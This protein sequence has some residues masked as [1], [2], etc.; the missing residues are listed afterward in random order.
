MFVHMQVLGMSGQ[1]M[2]HDF[3]DDLSL[4]QSFQDQSGTSKVNE[5][6]HG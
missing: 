4:N 1:W 6:A 5:V 2:G 3:G